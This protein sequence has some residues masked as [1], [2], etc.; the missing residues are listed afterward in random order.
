VERGRDGAGDEN[1]CR[2]IRAGRLKESERSRL[3]ASMT[4][5]VAQLVLRSN[6]L[7]TQAISMMETLKGPRI[8][9]KQH[10]IAVLEASGILNRELE[11]LPDAEQLTERRNNGEGLTRPELSVLLSYSKI[12]TYQFVGIGSS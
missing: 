12:V 3:L 9:A 8:G 1:Y 6:Y 5:D 2:A 10:F 4:D 7:Q 11:H